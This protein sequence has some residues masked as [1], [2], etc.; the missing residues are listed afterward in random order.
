MGYLEMYQL[1]GFIRDWSRN[2]KPL[3]G[4]CLGMQLF[5]ECSYENGYHKGLGLIEGEVLP[6][7][8]KYWHIGWNDVQVVESE[9]TFV[10][11]DSSYFYFNHSYYLGSASANVCAVSKCNIEFPS[12][13]KQGSLVGLQ[14]H[15]EKS[16]HA[17]HTLLK[18]VL[19]KIGHA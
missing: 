11:F 17:G 16:Q 12:I 7:G 14:F 5:A 10:P 2:S 18:T 1:T 13:V 8:E 4:I 6:L 19:E 3:L 9:E 15:P